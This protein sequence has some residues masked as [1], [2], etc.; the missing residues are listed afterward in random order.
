MWH[1]GTW[2]WW[3]WQCWVD[4]WIQGAQRFFQPEWFCSLQKTL[5]LLWGPN[6]FSSSVSVGETFLQERNL[7]WRWAALNVKSIHQNKTRLYSCK[8]GRKE[9]QFLFPGQLYF[10]PIHKGRHSCPFKGKHFGMAQACWTYSLNPS[11]DKLQDLTG[12]RRKFP[13]YFLYL[14]VFQQLCLKNKKTALQLSRWQQR[15]KTEK[16][17]GS[18]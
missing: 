10:V 7:G 13:I 6:F 2:L 5:F 14:E 18:F 1:L 8:K 9:G 17:K 3:P 11:F 16:T 12:G 4:S 15:W